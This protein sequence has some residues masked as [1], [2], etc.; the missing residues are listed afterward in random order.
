MSKEDLMHI[1]KI[2][3]DR[4]VAFLCKEILL[5]SLGMLLKTDHVFICLAALLSPLKAWLKLPVLYIFVVA[6]MMN[7][8]RAFNMTFLSVSAEVVMYEVQTRD[9]EIHETC[10]SITFYFMIELI[11]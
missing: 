7:A 2:P 1:H 5:R 10:H 8:K 3:N 11:F 4:F 6:R 9:H